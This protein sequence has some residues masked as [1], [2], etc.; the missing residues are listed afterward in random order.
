MANAKKTS[1]AHTPGP[2]VLRDNGTIQAQASIGK[3]A[4]YICAMPFSSMEEAKEISPEQIFNA[5]V[6]AAAP[7]LLQAAR[8]ARSFVGSI[9][10]DNVNDHGERALVDELD[11]AIG[12]AEGMCRDSRSFMFDEA[13]G[14]TA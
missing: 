3:W 2:W 8:N 13:D 9:V 6:I 12:A 14:N 1:S 10:S 11:K 5:G 4:D 7:Q